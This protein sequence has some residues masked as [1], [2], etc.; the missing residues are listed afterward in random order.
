M[1]GDSVPRLDS[2]FAWETSPPHPQPL[3]PRVQGERGAGRRGQKLRTG[4]GIKKPKKVATFGSLRQLLRNDQLAPESQRHGQDKRKP[5][6]THDSASDRRPLRQERCRTKNC[7]AGSRAPRTTRPLPPWCAATDPWCWTCVALGRAMRPMPKTLSR[8]LF[9]CWRGKPS[10]F[11][12]RRRSAVGFMAWPTGPL[13]RGARSLPAAVNT[14]ATL[15]HSSGQ[16]SAG[17]PPWSEVQQLMHAELTAVSDPYRAPLVLCFLEGRTQD[18]AA[19]QLQI[20]KTTLRTRLERGRR[21]PHAAAAPGPW[22]GCSP[23][24]LFVAGGNGLGVSA[25]G[26]LVRHGQGRDGIRERRSHYRAGLGPGHDPRGKCAQG[27]SCDE[28]KDSD[29]GVV[30]AGVGADSGWV[31]VSGSDRRT[32]LPPGAPLAQPTP[33]AATPK[34]CSRP[35]RK[36]RNK[37]RGYFRGACWTWRANRLLER[38]LFLLAASEPPAYVGK[39]AADGSFKVAVALPK[40]GQWHY[41]V[42]RIDG[43]GVDFIRIP[44]KLPT[45]PIELRVVRDLVI[46]GRIVN[47]EGKPIEGAKI[48]VTLHKRL[49]RQ[50]ARFLSYRVEEAAPHVGAAVWSERH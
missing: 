8:R 26:A 41:L 40:A 48:S 7:F 44:E 27:D 1:R 32:R 46:R 12:T 5:D 45:K 39:S 3:S 43:A 23:G 34:T 19:K 14:K 47:T 37:N 15:P 49:R 22:A 11:A 20:S 18:E 25:T 4:N 10:R 2:N 30:G 28:A 33:K 36:A 35:L 17:D 50:L 38:N 24:S 21:S 13:S 29:D 42:A 16:E 31:G 6:R 9:S